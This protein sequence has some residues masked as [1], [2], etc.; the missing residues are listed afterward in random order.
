MEE[1]CRG[2][3]EV[4]YASPALHVELHG[5]S[6]RVEVDDVAVRGANL[7]QPSQRGWISAAGRSRAILLRATFTFHQFQL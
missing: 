5:E 4:R 3:A 2:S 7:G 6:S 1:G